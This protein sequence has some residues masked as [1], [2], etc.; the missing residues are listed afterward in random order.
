MFAGQPA[1]LLAQADRATI[2]GIVTG[3]PAARPIADAKVT[4]IRIE[5]N[6]LIPLEDQ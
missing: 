3:T 1:F 4:V 2:E 6:S 5:T